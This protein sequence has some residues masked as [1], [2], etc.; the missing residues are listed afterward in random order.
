MHASSTFDIFF[1]LH[2]GEQDVKFTL[3]PNHDILPEGASISVADEDGRIVNTELILRNDYKVF[4]GHSWLRDEVGWYRAGWARITVLKDGLSPL[5]EGAFGLHHD[6]H[7]IQLRSNYLKTRHPLDPWPEEGDESMVVF[8]DSDVE[9]SFRKQG[10]TGRGEFEENVMCSSDGLLF[11]IQPDNAINRMILEPISDPWGFS[12]F[13]GGLTRRQTVDN[14]DGIYGGSGNSAGVNLKNSIGQTAGCPITR[15]VALMGVAADCTYMAA[16]DSNSSAWANVI[17]Q[18]NTASHLYESTFNITLGLSELHI[19]P[20]NCPGTAPDSAR[21]NLACSNNITIENRLDLFSVWRGERSN[22]T[23]AFWTLLTTCESGSA[24]GL[25]WLGQLCN[26][27]VT[28]NSD[29]GSHVSGANVIAR[30]AASTEWK[31]IAH[32]IGHTMGA[33]HDCTSTTC[34]QSNTATAS[35]CCPLSSTTCDAGGSY[36]MNPS[37]SDTMTNFSPCTIGNI[38]SAFGRKSV[39]SS[40]LTSNKGI[41]TISEHQ[42][43]NGIVEPGEDCDCGGVDGCANNKCCDSKTCKY[44]NGSVCE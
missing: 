11:N 17:N 16:F 10:L 37:T 29:D 21:W 42:C 9:N 25:A 27:D 1:T 43:G 31:V 14:G 7:H 39:N 35:Q 13:R 8:R 15:E 26:A 18:I 5:F 32:E 23:M 41:V 3:E 20:S 28:I 34:S 40:C 12:I 19:M 44:T 30:T 33:V 6:T 22:D 38:C 24:V 36:I 4:K 2:D